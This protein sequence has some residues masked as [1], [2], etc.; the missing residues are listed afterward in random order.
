MTRVRRVRRG[1]LLRARAAAQHLQGVQ[2]R[3]HG[4]RSAVPARPPAA[5]LQGVPGCE[6]MQLREAEVALWELRL[7]GSEPLK[8][9]LWH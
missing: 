6:H 4:R 1:R 8:L 7:M 2:G 9:Q 3:G 5:G